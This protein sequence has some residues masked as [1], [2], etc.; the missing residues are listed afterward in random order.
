[1][2]K[3]FSISALAV[4]MLALAG[5]NDIEPTTPKEDPIDPNLISFSLEQDAPSSRTQ[6]SPNHWRQIEWLKGDSIVI[7]CDKA[8]AGSPATYQVT[9]VISSTDGG[10]TTNR[11]ANIGAVGVGLSWGSETDDHI[12]YAGYGEGISIDAN[13][14]AKCKYNPDQILTK[15]ADGAWANMS[16][17]FMVAKETTK[18]QR[19][20]TASRGEET[21]PVEYESVNLTFRPIMTTIEVDVE[22]PST[23]SATIKALEITVPQ[24][25]DKT[26]IGTSG[27]S[28][29][30]YAYFD[31]DINTNVVIT[32]GKVTDPKEEKIIFT[33]AE[34]QDISAS[35]GVNITAILP[36]IEISN[37]S[38]ITIKIYAAD[39]SS[40][41]K[42]ATAVATSHK[43]VIT[44]PSWVSKPE[45]V[46]LVDL[47]LPSGTKWAK[48]NLGANAPAETGDYYCW[49]STVP[50]ATSANASW[51]LYFQKIGGSGKTYS[52]CG[53]SKD[54]LAGYDDIAGTEYD[55]AYA[56]LGGGEYHMPTQADIDELIAN[57]TWTWTTENEVNGYKVTSNI[58][59]YKDKFIFLPAAGQRESTSITNYNSAGYFWSS[60]IGSDYSYEAEA[61][62]FNGSGKEGKSSYRY[63]GFTIR[64]VYG[65]IKTIEA[66]DLGLPSGIKWANCNLGATRPEKYG[67]YYGWGSIKPYANG[68]DVDWPLYFQN[69]GGTAK[70]Y[71]E[72]GSDKDPLKAFVYPNNVSI[73]GLSKWDAAKQKLGEAW[74]MPTDDDIQELRQNCEWKWQENYKGKKGFLV[75]SRV[76][77]NSIF[78]PAAGY[79]SGT[80]TSSESVEGYYWS[81]NPYQS[82]TCASYSISSKAYHLKFDSNYDF[83]EYNSRSR[84]FP[85]RPVWDDS[86]DS[87][88]D[89]QDTDSENPYQGGDWE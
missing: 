89:R 14:V 40:R 84:G 51:P 7:R 85:I 22:G 10:I 9:E 71:Y 65:K 61:I 87:G 39:G 5:C 73:A 16:Q 35:K 70:E 2:N 81:S 26:Y 83:F 68:E 63:T 34:P 30:S 80:S 42:F 75:K 38:P 28:T 78:L 31:Y 32:D 43:V 58:D 44:T 45:T 37:T 3:I 23:G 19:K 29:S 77:N 53:T 79:R 49:G 15:G 41:A 13:G 57:C 20:Q 6:Y 66:V 74:R 64:P 62:F 25:Q 56:R 21:T 18:P 36:P 76:N 1:M 4:G 72:C 67:D 88:I 27:S 50:Y 46:E 48:W 55:A 8:R 24:S 33:L 86:I 59:G 12:F 11:K 54:P 17:A 60:S 82:T 47:G 52:D 69:I